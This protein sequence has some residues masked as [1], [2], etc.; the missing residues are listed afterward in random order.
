M[1]MK[2]LRCSGNK[3]EKKS[4]DN[5]SGSDSDKEEQLEISQT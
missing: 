2:F 5:S 4:N 3:V 1:S